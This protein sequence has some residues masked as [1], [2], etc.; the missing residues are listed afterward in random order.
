MAEC[1][2]GLDMSRIRDMFLKENYL[3]GLGFKQGYLFFRVERREIF[4][5]LYDE[6]DE[7]AAD[8]YNTEEQWGISARNIQNAFLVPTNAGH[9]LQIFRGLA[10]SAYKTY[11]GVP[12]TTPQHNLDTAARLS[13]SDFG[14]LSGWESPLNYPSPESEVWIPYRLD[15][16]FAEHNPLNDTIYPLIKFV[17]VRYDVS[18]LIDID[19][20]MKILERK[21]E[22]RLATI[23]GL[24][25]FD[26]H[27]KEYYN[28]LP[29]RLSDN[30]LAVERKLRGEE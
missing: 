7:I 3:L 24:T 21:T 1:S 20:V 25:D 6:R 29:I 26:Y 15:V 19:L 11:L 4:S 16:G 14:Y 28:K 9:I 10:P 8:T 12:Y 27:F 5:Y 23:G 2:V 13:K 30:R 22:C 17:I 18:P